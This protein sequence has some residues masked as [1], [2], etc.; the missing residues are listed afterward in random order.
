[1]SSR[2]GISPP[3]P[4]PLPGGEGVVAPSPPRG[5]GGGGGGWGEGGDTLIRRS[6]RC[7]PRRNQLKLRGKLLAAVG[8]IVLLIIVFSVLLVQRASRNVVWCHNPLAIPVNLHCKGRQDVLL[9]PWAFSAV[10]LPR[11]T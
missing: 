9:Q 1:M 3:H 6:G 10:A 5:G 7:I 8:V 2:P 11:G 4:N